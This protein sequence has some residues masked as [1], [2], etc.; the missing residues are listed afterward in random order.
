MIFDPAGMIADDILVGNARQVVDFSVDFRFVVFR[1]Q[2]DLF[3][4]RQRAMFEYVAL[5]TDCVSSA[6]D[7]VA[8]FDNFAKATFALASQPRY[9]CELWAHQKL[10]LF[11][12]LSVSRRSR[13]I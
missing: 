10:D 4:R 6:V 11:K 12:V 1:T 2:L 7:L 3:L 8:C 13:S 5:L 9:K